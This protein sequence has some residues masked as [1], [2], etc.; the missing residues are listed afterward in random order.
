[1]S[2]VFLD[3]RARKPETNLGCDLGQEFGEIWADFRLV[4]HESCLLA[5]DKVG[6]AFDMSHVMTHESCHDMTR[7]LTY[8]TFCFWP[9][10]VTVNVSVT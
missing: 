1:M 5:G 3:T 9:E 7:L 10:T 4:A 8:M 2:Q 6:R